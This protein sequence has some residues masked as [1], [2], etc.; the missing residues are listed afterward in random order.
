MT[1]PEPASDP[2]TVL[3]RML[4]ALDVLDW[5]TVGSCL[6]DRIRTDYTELFGGEVATPTRDELLDQWRG[7][8]PGFDA[9]QHLTGPVLSTPSDGGTRIDAHVRG[10]HHLGDSTWGVHGHY[11]GLVD[12][13]GR[14]AGLTLQV[15]YADG[16][17]DLPAQATARATENPRAP[18]G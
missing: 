12:V 13:T 2:S 8:L 6:A 7:F 1:A 11:V 5:E 9:T 16:D 15:F 14:I 18:R 17:D 3:T 10:Y 4:Y